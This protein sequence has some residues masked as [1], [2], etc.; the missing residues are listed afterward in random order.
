MPESPAQDTLLLPMN[1]APAQ[2]ERMATPEELHA[3]QRIAEVERA[4]AALATADRAFTEEVP[5]AQP[6]QSEA[7]KV[8]TEINPQPQI[9]P[10]S[11]HADFFL[12]FASI[13]DQHRI[14]VETGGEEGTKADLSGADLE[15]ADLTGVNLQSAVLQRAN[16]R[17]ADL[18][19][20]NLRNASLVQ[21][22]LCN[23][24][25]LGA[26]LR[27]ANLMGAT[28]YGAEGLWLGRL[29]GANL[30]DAMLPET[31]SSIDGSKAVWEATRSAR[32]FYFLMLTV[33]GLFT[34]FVATTSD[35]R[36]ILDGQTIPIA[37]LGNFLSIN[38]IYLTAPI[39]LL[40]LFVRF[41]FL[42]LRVWSS[43]AAL[44]A[45]FPDGQTVEQGG[46]WHLMGLVRRHFRWLRE[47]KTPMSWI[48][49]AIATSLAYW[50]V[51]A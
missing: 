43:M 17:G 34:L 3:L 4:I 14:W 20:A 47:T 25:L 2:T 13:L 24:N 1:S 50:T 18:S 6:F 37:R 44:P 16:L 41:Q 22:D 39:A 29:G 51:P 35:P 49:N 40:V 38:A 21:A 48:E 33:C 26:E 27:G 12:E 45:V 9:A 7:S 32:W 30:Y 15:N 8:A 46:P 19:M 31:I 28:M 42:L 11:P 10:Y 23:A 5:V 36:L